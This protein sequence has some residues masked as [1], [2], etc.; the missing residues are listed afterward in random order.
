M[1][2]DSPI[3]IFSQRRT[4]QPSSKAAQRH[5]SLDKPIGWFFDSAPAETAGA[6]YRKKKVSSKAQNA[7]FLQTQ[8]GPVA[9]RLPKVCS[10]YEWVHRA[11]HKVLLVTTPEGRVAYQPKSY[12]L[13]RALDFMTGKPVENAEAEIAQ[14]CW[15]YFQAK[16]DSK[17]N[18][19][20]VR[21]LL[22]PAR[23]GEPFALVGTHHP[24]IPAEKTAPE[25]MSGGMPPVI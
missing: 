3:S 10:A 7:L 21:F 17:E 8:Q 15:A 9:Y 1:K 25:E 23:P 20:L 6:T 12:R 18:R 5:T 4:P 16:P 2:I 19:A 22:E 13:I 14:A 11:Q 24:H